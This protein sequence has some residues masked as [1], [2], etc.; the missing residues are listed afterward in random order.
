MARAMFSPTGPPHVPSGFCHARPSCFP[1]VLMMR[2]AYWLTLEPSCFSSAY[3][4]C[5][6]T[7]PRQIW[8]ASSSFLPI[9]PIEDL[10]PAGLRVEAPL[11]ALPDDRDRERPVLVAD[12]EG[13]AVRVL[14]VRDDGELL[15]SLRGEG[16]GGLPVLRG[17]PGRD[18]VVAVRAE[19]RLEGRPVEALG[20]RDQ[21]VGGFLGGG[22]R[23]LRGRGGR[24]RLLLR[25]GAGG[26]DQRAR[27]RGGAEQA[28]RT[29]AVRQVDGRF[30]VSAPAHRRLPP[31]SAA[32]PDRPPPREPALEDPLALLARALAPL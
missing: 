8:M 26:G 13:G 19:D 1:G 18:E 16:R 15:A 31:A 32:A 7:Y 30:H 9:R 27:A 24:D 11:P 23:L 12:D 20:R 22:E 28:E 10:L 25:R 3:S 6:S 14:R 21:G 5:A 29:E 2:C 4:C 17:L